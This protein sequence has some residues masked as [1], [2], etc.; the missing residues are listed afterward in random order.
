M[1]LGIEILTQEVPVQPLTNDD[2]VKPGNHTPP[3]P[4]DGGQS[5]MGTLDT[6]PV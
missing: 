6:S 4:I 1:V 3:I 5:P 2:V